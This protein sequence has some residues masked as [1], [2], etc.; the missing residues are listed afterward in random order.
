MP[1]RPERPA[2]TPRVDPK[3]CQCDA[4]AGDVFVVA[5][6]G[7]PMALGVSCPA[8]GMRDVVQLLLGP[9]QDFVRRTDG[10]IERLLPGWRCQHPGCR[11]QVAVVGGL[12]SIA[13]PEGSATPWGG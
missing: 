11:A 1:V 9:P 6:F 7:R 2:R 10:G 5:H 12:F 4:R 8:C 13:P 3:V